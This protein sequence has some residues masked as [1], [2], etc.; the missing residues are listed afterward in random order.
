M[1]VVSRKLLS[2]AALP[3]WPICDQISKIWPN[4]ESVWPQKFWPLFTVW[5][6]LNLKFIYQIF[7]PGQKCLNFL[8]CL[9]ESYFKFG[10][11]SIYRPGNPGRRW[12]PVFQTAKAALMTAAV[13]PSAVGHTHTHTKT[14]SDRRGE[15]VCLE[16][17]LYSASVQSLPHD[18]DFRQKGGKK[19]V[20]ARWS[21]IRKKKLAAIRHDCL[22]SIFIGMEYRRHWRGFR[23]LFGEKWLRSSCQLYHMPG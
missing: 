4:F 5:P 20:T 18:E 11:M 2:A 21:S 14:T 3:V 23:F 12:L 15:W 9:A 19:P 16:L 17:S 8:F 6:N 10:R 13:V 22:P 1:R 7:I